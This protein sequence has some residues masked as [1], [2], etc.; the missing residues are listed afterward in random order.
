MLTDNGLVSY[1]TRGAHWNTMCEACFVFEFEK[2]VEK[3]ATESM[4]TFCVYY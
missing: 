3:S 4:P 1:S 2:R